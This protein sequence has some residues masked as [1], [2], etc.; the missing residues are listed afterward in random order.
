VAN[1]SPVED[2]GKPCRSEDEPGGIMR[3][4]LADE[5]AELSRLSVANVTPANYDGRNYAC[6][7][8]ESGERCRK[9]MK[10]DHCEKFPKQL[11][12]VSETEIC[13]TYKDDGH[14]KGKRKR[15]GVV[16]SVVSAD[17][18]KENVVDEVLDLEKENQIKKRRT[19]KKAPAMKD[20]EDDKLLEIA[21]KNLVSQGVVPAEGI[22]DLGADLNSKSPA[23]QAVMRL[24]L[25]RGEGNY[26]VISKIEKRPASPIGK[27]T[28]V[29]FKSPKPLLRKVK[30]TSSMTKPKNNDVKRDQKVNL[31]VNWWEKKA[32]AES[33]ENLCKED[34]FCRTKDPSTN[35]V[36]DSEGRKQTENVENSE[37]SSGN[38][39][40]VSDSQ[41]HN[42]NW[43]SRPITRRESE[44][45]D[46]MIREPKIQPIGEGHKNKEVV[47]PDLW[48]PSLKFGRKNQMV[49]A[50]QTS[51]FQGING[52]FEI[53]GCTGKDV[54]GFKGGEGP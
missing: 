23:L 27:R 11:C 28:P 35:P 16:L 4:S 21:G 26:R 34:S 40:A 14:Y 36:R 49:G 33:G 24:W 8:M 53:Q 39:Q 45:S 30:K 51:D 9:I 52:N 50:S 12:C 20:L 47:G 15:E 32:V 5:T 43:K 22:V 17:C 7:C 3:P 1:D 6:G 19:R 31:M 48:Q 2:D 18:E 44:I 42:S 54:K 41:K 25:R 10:M 37:M 13:V 29:A 38:V 46:H